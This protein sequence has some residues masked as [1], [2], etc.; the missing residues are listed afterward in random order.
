MAISNQHRLEILHKKLKS[1]QEMPM[2]A[3]IKWYKLKDKVEVGINV[4]HRLITLT[5]LIPL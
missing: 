3:L 4:I 1:I 5:Y 2:L